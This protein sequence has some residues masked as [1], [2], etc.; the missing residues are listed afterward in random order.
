MKSEQIKKN[1]I[2]FVTNIMLQMLTPDLPVTT[3][4]RQVRGMSCSPSKRWD[5]LDFCGKGKNKL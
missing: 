5:N 1:K 3:C 4:S 2:W